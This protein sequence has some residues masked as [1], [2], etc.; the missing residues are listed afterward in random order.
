MDMD[1]SPDQLAPSDSK[2]IELL[3]VFH[4][5]KTRVEGG[6][7]GK[8]FKIVNRRGEAS[9]LKTPTEDSNEELVIKKDIKFLKA[10]KGYPNVVHYYS[11]VDIGKGRDAV[12]IPW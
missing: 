6:T 8:V 5:K 4:D 2:E 1:Q 3:S 10:V 9:G 7:F 11:E 12:S